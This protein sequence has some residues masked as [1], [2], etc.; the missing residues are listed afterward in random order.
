MFL[1]YL[2][3]F[4]SLLLPT[5]C[6]EGGRRGEE[7]ERESACVR[8]RGVCARVI[9]V[10]IHIVYAMQRVEVKRINRNRDYSDVRSFANFSQL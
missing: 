2:V 6:K 10:C 5:I 9:C 3:F 8:V 4:F 1:I 7:R